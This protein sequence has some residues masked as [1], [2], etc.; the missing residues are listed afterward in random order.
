VT[1]IRPE[2]RELVA[3]S[4]R[5]PPGTIGVEVDLLKANDI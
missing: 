2:L 3:A 4:L 5:K 1:Q